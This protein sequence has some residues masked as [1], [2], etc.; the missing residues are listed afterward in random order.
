[1]KKNDCFETLFIFWGQVIQL[2]DF[3]G[4]LPNGYLIKRKTA[5]WK[6]FDRIFSF[7]PISEIKKVAEMFEYDFWKKFTRG[8]L[9]KKYQGF[10]KWVADCRFSILA[11]SHS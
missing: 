4:A 8:Y 2:R 3:G 10:A 9:G 11:G 1:M 6:Q 5:L 7:S